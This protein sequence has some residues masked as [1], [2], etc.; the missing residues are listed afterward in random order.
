MRVLYVR[1][2]KQKIPEKPFN[3]LKFVVDR[4]LQSDPEFYF[5]QIGANDGLRADPI[6][7]L[8][9]QYHLRGLLVEPM[10]DIFK[11]LKAN[12]ASEPQLSF[13][14]CAIGNR[15]GLTSLYRFM[16]DTPVPNDFFHGLARN[17]KEYMVNRAKSLG[18]LK[19][20]EELHVPTLTFS[21]LLKKHE[22]KNLSLLQV[23]TEG[24]DFEILKMLFSYSIFPQI[25]N[26]EWSEL[27]YDDRR[28][29]KLMLLD[30]GYSFI[31]CGSDTLCLLHDS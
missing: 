31:D 14:N 3:V 13:E 30:K 17:D 9:M 8:V 12:Y 15:D 18:L 7:P 28:E 5:V 19:Y 6:R 11:E 1:L 23:D 26:Y 10:P 27:S 16:R 2:K 4:V 21:S 25:I 20:I 24:Y 29:C 22:V